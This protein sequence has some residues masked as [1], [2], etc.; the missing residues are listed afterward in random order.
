MDRLFIAGGNMFLDKPPTIA[1]KSGQYNT[2]GINWDCRHEPEGVEVKYKTEHDLYQT[3]RREGEFVIC[4]MS[5]RVRLSVSYIKPVKKKDGW[6]AVFSLWV[7]DDR[8]RLNG[9]KKEWEAEYTR[10]TLDECA[11][12]AMAIAY[13]KT[14]EDM[15]DGL[16]KQ[17]YPSNLDYIEV[18]D[19]QVVHVLEEGNKL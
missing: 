3:I 4:H 8:R 6:R 1:Y 17:M 16:L 10:S 5:Y 13:S 15:I 18:V 9:H 14:V 12:N 7:Y 2:A 11:G 19:K